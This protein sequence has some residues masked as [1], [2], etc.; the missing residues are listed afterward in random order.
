VR[1]PNR[2]RVAGEIA[3]ASEQANRAMH[4][5]DSD[6]QQKLAELQEQ[7]VAVKGT[8]ESLRELKDGLI[9]QAEA[10]FHSEESAYQSNRQE[11][12]PVLSA[13]L[14]ILT[15]ESEYQQTLLDHES[16]LAR[17]ETLTGGT[18]R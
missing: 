18:L 16:A 15:L 4:E 12:A 17:I 13:L 8:D 9:P 6:V 5:M 11:L 7:L 2:G 1:L 10:L 3:Q 14:D